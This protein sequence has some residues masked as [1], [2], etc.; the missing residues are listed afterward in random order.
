MLVPQDK[1]LEA[2]IKYDGQAI[3]EICNYFGIEFNEKSKSAL[4]PF[5]ADKNPSFSGILR[6]RVFVVL[7]VQKASIL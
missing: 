5:H 6:L 2:K 4:C 1:L 3:Q 7:D